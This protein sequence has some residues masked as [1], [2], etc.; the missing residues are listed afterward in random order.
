MGLLMVQAVALSDWIGLDTPLAVEPSED[1]ERKGPGGPV[2]G[3]IY[4][5]GEK[6]RIIY[7]G[8]RLF[9]E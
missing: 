5:Q 4:L 6:N 7:Q 3:M 2:G 1:R 9:P 8:L